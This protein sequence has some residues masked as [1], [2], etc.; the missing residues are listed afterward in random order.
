M[1]DKTHDKESVGTPPRSQGAVMDM[2]GVNH[3][4]A[5]PVAAPVAPAE[6]S[7]EHRDVVQAVKALNATEMFG[8]ENQLTFQMDRQSKRMVVQVV[9]RQTKEVVSQ[10]PADCVLRL[11]EDLEKALGEPD[12]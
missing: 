9:N 3:N 4:L 10:I 8:Q 7:A 11:S 12:K 5:A 2:S 1:A 6:N